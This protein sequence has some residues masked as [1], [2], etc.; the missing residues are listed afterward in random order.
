MLVARLGAAARGGAVCV[1][2][3]DGFV[4]GSEVSGGVHEG[5]HLGAEADAVG[6][7]S[8]AT[9]GEGREGSVSRVVGRGRGCG[10]GL[11]A[12]RASSTATGSG[13]GDG[14]LRDSLAGARGDG[15]VGAAGEGAREGVRGE[16]AARRDDVGAG[17]DD[18][19][20]GDEREEEGDARERWRGVA[21]ALG[22]GRR[23]RR[24]GRGVGGAAGAADAVEE[25]DLLLRARRATH[26]ARGVRRDA[27]PARASLLRLEEPRLARAG[28]QVHVGVRVAVQTQFATRAGGNARVPPSGRP[29]P[30]EE[31]HRGGSLVDRVRPRVVPRSA[32]RALR[33]TR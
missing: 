21:R 19:D 18:E 4:L 27:A 30:S 13:S 22:E 11:V 20:G 32:A 5:E 31:P 3:H 7:E 15:G 28:M 1:I 17:G 9:L 29:L 2:P 24:L 26:V 16:D 10:S 33:S 12:G 8:D 25:P 23:C 14:G 6:G